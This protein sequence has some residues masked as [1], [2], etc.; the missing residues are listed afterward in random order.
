MPIGST[1]IDNLMAQHVM[2]RLT[3]IEDEIE[4][5]IEELT[6]AM[7][8][9]R[10]QTIKH[11]FP[12]PVVPEFKLDVPI[13]GRQTFERAGIYDSA[14]VINR[15][16]LKII[17]DEQ[18]QRIFQLVDQRLNDLQRSHP[19]ES[20]SYIVL[21]G[22]FGSSPYLLGE[23]KQRYESNY[24]FSSQNISNVHIMRIQDP[25]L[26]VTRGLVREADTTAGD[27]CSARQ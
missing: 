4:E 9:G 25:Q 1:L 7:L 26:S 3:L 14:M 10:F 12:D 18:V 13:P 22:G 2:E 8:T 6:E 15:E 19:Q 21:S 5:S 20:V 16:D 17:F 24:G 11:S 27:C 23:L